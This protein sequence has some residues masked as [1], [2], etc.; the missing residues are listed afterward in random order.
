MIDVCLEDSIEMTEE[1][2]FDP[3]GW[4]GENK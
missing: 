1:R 3:G 4:A 2:R